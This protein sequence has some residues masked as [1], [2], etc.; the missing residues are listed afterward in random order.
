MPKLKKIF[1]AALVECLC[2]QPA[3]L[4]LDDLDSLF[5]FSKQNNQEQS[6]LAISSYSNRYVCYDMDVKY[7]IIYYNLI[8]N[9]YNV[10]IF[11]LSNTISDLIRSYSKYHITVVATAVNVFNFESN[12]FKAR[13]AALFSNSLRIPVL[14]EV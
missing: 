8:R 12:M 4:C 2:Y 1:E 5:T 14:N 9:T 3:I 13:G 6:D 11:R 10:F 7:L